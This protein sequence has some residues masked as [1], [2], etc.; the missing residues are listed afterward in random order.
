[1][2]GVGTT[3]PDT[4]VLQACGMQSNA[5]VA[6]VFF[7]GT[8]DNNA[9]VTFGDG[10]RCTAGSLIRLGTKPTPSGS[11]SYPEVGDQAISIRGMVTP[12]SGAMR[13]Y[14]VY[15]RNPNPSFCR[16]GTFNVTN[17]VAIVW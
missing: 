6:S 9:G 5:T 1:M 7:Q 3:N 2:T 8:V 10:V 4:L 15:Y 12:G 16:V 13:Y 17:G 11:A 14:Q